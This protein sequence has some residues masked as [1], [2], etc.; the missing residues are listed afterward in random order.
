M[1]LTALQLGPLTL[2]VGHLFNDAVPYKSVHSNGR[3]CKSAWPLCHVD[4][5]ASGNLQ[6]GNFS[7]A[8]ASLCPQ[9][10]FRLTSASVTSSEFSRFISA[11]C[12]SACCC[13]KRF[14]STIEPAPVFVFTMAEWMQNVTFHEFRERRV[15]EIRE[16]LPVSRLS[17]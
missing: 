2:T 11:P 13:R 8:P 6:N 4:R 7:S 16:M 12:C 3:P 5:I 14:G 1:V 9:S 10:L 17:A 15:Q